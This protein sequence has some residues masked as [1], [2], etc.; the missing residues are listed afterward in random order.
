M[1]RYDITADMYDQRYEQEQRAKYEAALRHTNI[2]N[3]TILDAG[4]GTGLFFSRAAPIAKNVVAFDVSG[5]LL[6]QAKKQAKYFQ[7]VFVLQADADHLPFTDSVFDA[8]FAFTV[9]QNIPTPIETLFELKRVGKTNGNVV[10]TGL[11]KVFSCEV[12]SELVAS[13]GLKTV[14]FEDEACLKCYVAVLAITCTSAT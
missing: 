12:F 8:A 5:K 14:S 13:S 11:K 1:N 4:C 2:A 6:R 3:A 10:V 7:N 9:L